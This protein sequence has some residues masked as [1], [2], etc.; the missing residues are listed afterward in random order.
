GPVRAKAHEAAITLARA[1]FAA[2]LV[3]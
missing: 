1:F 2:K 3:R